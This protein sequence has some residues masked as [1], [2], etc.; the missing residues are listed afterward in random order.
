MLVQGRGAIATVEYS[1]DEAAPEIK[2]LLDAL[3]SCLLRACV[4]LHH[5]VDIDLY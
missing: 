4:L 5:S 3:V 2:K 1:G